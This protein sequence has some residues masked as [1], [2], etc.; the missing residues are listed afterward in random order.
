MKPPSTY[1]AI[2][3]AGTNVALDPNATVVTPCG[4]HFRKETAIAFFGKMAGEVCTEPRRCLYCMEHV[5]RFKDDPEPYNFT[6]TDL[7][8]ETNAVYYSRADFKDCGEFSRCLC[9]AV[10][11]L[12]IIFKMAD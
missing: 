6:A 5:D 10:C 3:G 9:E 1:G 2:P 7:T 8:S 4:H 11:C 12:F